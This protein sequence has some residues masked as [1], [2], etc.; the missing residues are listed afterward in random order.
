MVIAALIVINPKGSNPSFA[1]FVLC[2]FLRSRRLD[3]FLRWCRCCRLMSSRAVRLSVPCVVLVAGGLSRFLARFSVRLSLALV[4]RF[5]C[6]SSS[7]LGARVPL[8]FACAIALKLKV[9]QPP[10]GLQQWNHTHQ[11]ALEGI[12][13]SDLI[14]RLGFDSTKAFED[15][16]AVG[17]LD[18]IKYLEEL[19]GW[20]N[21]PIETGSSR[22]RFFSTK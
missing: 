3:R 10:R 13:R 1:G 22:T 11:D 7:L 20:K 18:P 5:G 12:T 15:T 21:R 9:S 6:G 2:S 17:E 19:S 16:A 4:P 8:F 14:K